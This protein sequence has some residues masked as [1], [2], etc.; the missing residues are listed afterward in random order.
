MVSLQAALRRV[1]DDIP[2]I[3]SRQSIEET[4]RRHGYVW[5]A[6][7]LNPAATIQ[8]FVR[9]IIEK[10]VSGTEVV[11][12][13]GGTFTDAAWCQA[14][15]RIPLAVLRDLADQ[16]SH[17]VRRHDDHGGT[18]EW[19][20][21]QVYIVDGSNFSMSDTPDLRKHFGDVPG[22]KPGCGFPIAHWLAVFDLHTGVLVYDEAAAYATSDL[23]HTLAAQETLLPGTILLG[24]DSFGGHA[25]ISLLLQRNLHGVFP[26]HHMR[27]VDFTPGREGGRDAATG[28]PRSKWIRS[29]G[30]N[31]QVVEMYKPSQRPK[32][33]TRDQ[34]RALP[35]SIQVREIRRTIRRK[36]FRPLELTVVTTL[37]DP[38]QYPADEIVALR[39]R[40]W[41]IETDIRHLKTTMNMEVLRCQTAQG[42]LK[43][44]AVFTIVYNL[45]R[46]VM[47]ESARKQKVDPTRLSFADAL[48]WVCHAEADHE[49]PTLKVV[50]LRPGRIEPRALKR[51][52]KPFDLMNRPRDE[53]RKLSLTL[54]KR[55]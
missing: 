50:P 37:L 30:K 2:R 41:E 16:V 9:Q 36:G 33:L 47:L 23:Q 1:K 52:P 4:C 26:S 55:R 27:T 6:G 53:M 11:R 10:N 29:L 13:A 46:A 24:D 17:R 7:P 19:K 20:N 22:Q 14:R 38:T 51:R 5:R 21:H 12:L 44:L 42:V 8:F 49:W 45:I 34:F 35:D 18:L 3:L 25:Q 39:G 54:H 31:D 32:W 40:R 28:M 43:E 15:Q 48:A